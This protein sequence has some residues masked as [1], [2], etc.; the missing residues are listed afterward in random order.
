[1]VS[2]KIFEQVIEHITSVIKK[3]PP[4]G[5]ALWEELVRVHPADIASFFSNL[6]HEEIKGLF[7]TFPEHLKVEVFQDLSDSLKV[8]CLS[9]LDDHSRAHILN[10]TPLDELTD[11][12]DELSDEDLKQYLRLLHKQDRDA[13]VSLLQF[14]PESAGGI[15]DTDVLTLMED[16]TVEKSI[17]V[18]QRLQPDQDLH[19][20]IFVTNQENQL[21]GYIHLEDLVLKHPTT[22][23]SSFLKKNEMI[24]NVNEDQE[25]VA[26]RMV[27]YGLMTVP[28]VDNNG[29]FLGV[30]SS[31]TLVDII[32]QE[33][34]EDVYKMS[35]MT[36]IKQ[37]YFETSFFRMFYER[38]S[39]LIIL[40]IAQTFSSIILEKYQ[41]TISGFLLYFIT[42]LIS[43]GGNASSQTSA[44]VIQGMASGEIN[45]SNMFRFMRREFFMAAIIAFVL[46]IFSFI[47]ILITHGTG[48]IRDSLAVSGSLGIIV[49]VAVILGSCIPLILKK[50]RLDPAYSAGPGLATVMDI[51]GLLIYCYIG[52]LVLFE[53]G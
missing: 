21:V 16:F 37:T 1:M 46:G 44:I 35:A 43:T 18:L 47:R 38:C 33:A 32:E 5:L 34:S 9:F 14:N 3:E 49:L 45:Q 6:S 8:Y 41:A 52:K 48:R 26:Q 42:M 28:V 10:A 19:R 24:V 4:L 50:L 30:I 12:F 2:E 31:D 27:H 36:P 7:L 29:L 40:L 15:M 17:R 39:I 11:L 20:S 13:V 51:L 53:I 23:L 22:R 25:V